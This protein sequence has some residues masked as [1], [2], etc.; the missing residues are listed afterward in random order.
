MEKISDILKTKQEREV[1]VEEAGQ[2]CND[3]QGYG[4]ECICEK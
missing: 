1:S 2:L 3:C 4:V